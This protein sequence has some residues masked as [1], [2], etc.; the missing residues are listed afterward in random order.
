MTRL[1]EIM[2]TPTSLKPGEMLVR[3]RL[4]MFYE[5]LKV[6]KV[7]DNDT[8]SNYVEIVLVDNVG[9]EINIEERRDGFVVKL[10]MA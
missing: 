6:V 1:Y 9:N 2:T 8:R 5:P 7:N 4:R 3:T 10:D